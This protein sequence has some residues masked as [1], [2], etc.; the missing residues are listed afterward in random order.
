MADEHV[1][2]ADVDGAPTE[3][4]RSGWQTCLI[5][6][7]VVCVVLFVLAVLIALW[8]SRNWRSWTADFATEG[9]R[10]GMKDSQLD[11]QE[12]QQI[13]VQVERVSQAFRDNAISAEQ[14]GNLAEKLVKSPL[15][16]MLMA[17]AIEK[18][19]LAKSGLS[20]E[21][22]VAGSQSLQRF[23]R[24]VVDE[25]IK[26]PGIDAAMAHVADRRP[27]NQWELRKTLTDDELRAFFAEA[28]KQADEAGIPEQPAEIDPSEEVRK[29]VDAALAPPAASPPTPPLETAPP[30][31]VPSETAP[32]EETPPA[33]APP[34]AAPTA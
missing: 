15:F 2:T 10:Q 5:G 4:K 8:I 34:E 23:I 11:P 9:I 30:A 24:G 29:I 22:K 17:T 25:K 31:V 6:C 28:K 1:F 21:E 13:M 20:D 7:L 33:A 26:Q 14:L 12:Q 16:S 18:Q 32:A 3:K 27:N 19:Y